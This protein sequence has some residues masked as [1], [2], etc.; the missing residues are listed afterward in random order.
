MFNPYHPKGVSLITNSIGFRNHAN[1]DSI[2]LNSKFRI[3]NLGDSFSNGYHV[4]QKD[5][6]GYILQSVLQKKTHSDNI[7]VL[8]VEVSDPALRFSISFKLY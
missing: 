3:L 8:N 4:D 6:F 7:E 1:Y 5:F 2:K